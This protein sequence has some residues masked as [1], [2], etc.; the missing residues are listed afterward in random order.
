M[1]E[2]RKYSVYVN[3]ERFLVTKEDYPNFKVGEIAY[4]KKTH[5]SDIVLGLEYKS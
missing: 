5:I 2:V 3:G 4:I 1:K